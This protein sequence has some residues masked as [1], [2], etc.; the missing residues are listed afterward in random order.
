MHSKGRF[1]NAMFGVTLR[2]ES[3]VVAIMLMLLFL[4]FVFLFLTLTAQPAEGQTFNVIYSFPGGADGASPQA[5]LTMDAAG[6]LYGTTESGGYTGND[7]QSNEYGDG[8]GTVFR[9]AKVSSRWVLTT[10]Y[11]FQ[12]GTDGMW[13]A[14]R[15]VF[16]PDG[17]LYGTTPQGGQGTCGP[18]YEFIG[19][20]TVFQLQRSPAPIP[21]ANPWVHNMIHQ[22]TGGTD[23][24]IPGGDVAFDHAGNLYGVTA[25]GGLESCGY[26][27]G[28]A[29]E[30]FPFNDGWQE[31]VIYSFTA[32]T[33][34]Q[35]G[36]IF[37]RVGNL[38]G[39]DDSV[40][41]LIRSGI[42]WTEKTILQE[43]GWNGLIYD[44][45]G[46]L[47]GSSYPD[48]SVFE[49]S[50]SQDG[51]IY[52][53]LYQLNGGSRAALSMDAAG[54]LYGTQFSGGAY[55]YGAVFRLTHGSGGWTYTSL[56]DFTG[57]TDGGYPLSNVTFD[58]DGDLYGT[59]EAGGSNDGVVWEITP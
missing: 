32:G 47:Y 15:V 54:N 59:A 24:G 7:C 41:Q 55:E 23:G 39:T 38:Y 20:G 1:P 34:P 3:A 36:V 12:G 27:C 6:N 5:G 19:C 8:C 42:Q 17:S 11:T 45:S 46:N 53:Q 18:P 40:F 28:V 29:Y 51:W 49:L 26:E 25:D 22:F 31:S 50:P 35:S 30:F 9:L 48:G 33:G 44:P 2:P 56:H 57:G 4:V 21:T 52:T 10:L 13:P 37:D 14:A 16:G 43:G 58:A